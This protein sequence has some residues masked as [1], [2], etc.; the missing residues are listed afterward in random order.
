MI[1]KYERQGA[2]KAE[3][4]IKEKYE[5]DL[6]SYHKVGSEQIDVPETPI[7]VNQPSHELDCQNDT[8]GKVK[9]ELN[10]DLEQDLGSYRQTIV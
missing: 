2:L 4:S 5:T 7:Q 8:F 9:N 1:S 3:A 6:L 10:E